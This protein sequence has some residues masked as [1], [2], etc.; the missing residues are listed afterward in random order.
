MTLQ[1]DEKLHAAEK[2]KGVRRRSF[3]STAWGS[4]C[5]TLTSS[6]TGGGQTT[7]FCESFFC[8]SVARISQK[9]SSKYDDDKQK[10]LHYCVSHIATTVVYSS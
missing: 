8:L 9:F 10:P 1:Y 5:D 2:A 7:V 6:L 3:V 4:H